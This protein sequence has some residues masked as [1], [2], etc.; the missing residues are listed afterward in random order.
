MATAGHCLLT[1]SGTMSDEIYVGDPGSENRYNGKWA[2]VAR[3]YFSEDYRGNTANGGIS[4]ADIAIVRLTRPIAQST[5]IF[6]ASESQLLQLKSSAAKLR[7][8]GYGATDDSG[9]LTKTPNYYE[10]TFSS[11]YSTDPNQSFSESPV[12][13]PCRGD[14]GGPVLSITPTKV[15][16]IGIVTGA[17][18]SN[19][20]SKKQPNGNFVTIF[21]IMNRFA[22]LVAAGLVESQLLQVDS[23]NQLNERILDL[24]L[25]VSSLEEELAALKESNENLAKR[26]SLYKKSGMK[27]ISCVK[28]SLE[29]TVVGPRPIC[30]K[31]FKV[32]KA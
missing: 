25:E 29:K 4:P 11:M 15:M 10:T 27:E 7:V 24:S 26:I 2:K 9:T 21:T 14:S 30:P 31:G 23:E 12:S 20:C 28:G 19:A 16:L 3:V 13:G 1:E 22:N 5:F 18:P 32:A 17:Y 8:I 6:L